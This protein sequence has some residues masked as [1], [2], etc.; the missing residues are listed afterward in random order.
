MPRRSLL[1]LALVAAAILAAPGA[2]AQS[3]LD[4]LLGASPTPT[5]AVVMTPE[6]AGSPTGSVPAF[7]HFFHAKSADESDGYA[8]VFNA[9]GTIPG[10]APVGLVWAAAAGVL[11]HQTGT[12][13]VWTAPHGPF[14]ERRLV[15]ITVTLSNGR[16]TLTGTITVAVEKDGKPHVTQLDLPGLKGTPED[17]EGTGS[18]P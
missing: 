6:P 1:V 17:F 12:E 11:S 2:H 4:L 9:N 18:L 5:P 14:N 13:V 10:N 8:L 7:T 16:T 3:A 15:P